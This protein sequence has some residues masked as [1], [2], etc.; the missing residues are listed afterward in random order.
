[1]VF[2]ARRLHSDRDR[3]CGHGIQP[4]LSASSLT[5]LTALCGHHFRHC[6]GRSQASLP[7]GCG[8]RRWRRPDRNQKCSYWYLS[9]SLTMPPVCCR[10]WWSDRNPNGPRP[11]AGSVE[12]SLGREIER[13]S[14][15]CGGR[16]NIFC[17][18]RP[19]A[20]SVKGTNDEMGQ[21]LVISLARRALPSQ[22]LPA[23]E[24]ARRSDD[25]S[26]DRIPSHHE[27]RAVIGAVR[28]IEGRGDAACRQA[29]DGTRQT[30]ARRGARA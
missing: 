10:C 17:L 27:E 3:Y 15:G 12:R 21:K 29:G 4:G 13:D 23:R 11:F 26:R 8:R 14:A 7:G 24:I 9:A 5:D 19:E 18:L 28:R 20:A 2:V 6:T 1:M 30:G 22:Q 16:P 25:Q